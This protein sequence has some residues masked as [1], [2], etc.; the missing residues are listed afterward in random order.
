MEPLC[1]TLE[2]NI[3]LYINNTYKKRERQ[4]CDQTEG[5]SQ[6]DHYLCDLVSCLPLPQ[7]SQGNIKGIIPVPACGIVV[8]ILGDSCRV[9]GSVWGISISLVN[10]PL[11]IH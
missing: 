7:F 3:R 5:E 1:G 4:V 8:R 9:L 10:D 2:T 11:P 6:L